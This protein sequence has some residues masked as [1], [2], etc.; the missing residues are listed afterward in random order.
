MLLLKVLGVFDSQYEFKGLSQI[1]TWGNEGVQNRD[2]L[3][4]MDVIEIIDQVWKDI[5]ECSIVR[6]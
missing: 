1:N 3:N 6:C 5:G 2:K 4:G